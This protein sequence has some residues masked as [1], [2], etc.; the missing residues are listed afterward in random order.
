MLF[1]IMYRVF[2]LLLFLKRLCIGYILGKIKKLSKL[3]IVCDRAPQYS[4][5]TK[6]AHQTAKMYQKYHL[7]FYIPIILVF[8][9]KN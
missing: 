9:L 5:D 7:F 1:W 4:R 6:E 3:T 8:F 2:F